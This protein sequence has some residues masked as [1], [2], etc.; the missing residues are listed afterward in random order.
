MRLS[1]KAMRTVRTICALLDVEKKNMSHIATLI[2]IYA[3]GNGRSRMAWI[4]P[5]KYDITRRF[6]PSR[7]MQKLR[8]E[9]GQCVS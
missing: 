4:Y 6:E 7:S 9:P 8:V 1:A 5:F 3:A 2:T